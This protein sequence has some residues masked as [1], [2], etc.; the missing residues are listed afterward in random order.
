MTGSQDPERSW[1]LWA[2]ERTDAG[3]RNELGV[4]PQSRQEA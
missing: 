3:V 1:R 4:K 2:Q